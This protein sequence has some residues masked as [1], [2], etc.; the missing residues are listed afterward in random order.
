MYA[1]RVRGDLRLMFS[2]YIGNTGVDTVFCPLCPGD[3]KLIYIQRTKEYKCPQC[4]EVLDQS[5]RFTR[6]KTRL[7]APNALEN[8]SITLSQVSAHEYMSRSTIKADSGKF[9]SPKEAWE[10]DSNV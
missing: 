3:V 1:V 2:Q 4:G 7:V 6:R 9:S 8:Q 10:N 5:S